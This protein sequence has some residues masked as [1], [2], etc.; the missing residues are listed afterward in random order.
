M[1]APSWDSLSSAPPSAPDW[2]SLSA[3][4]PPQ[5]GPAPAIVDPNAPPSW[6]DLQTAD[7]FHSGIG[8]TLM[9]AEEGA[10]RGA[11]GGFS[12]FVPQE[13][14]NNV[15]SA[16]TGGASDLF[17]N[18]T[19]TDT[20]EGIQS[21]LEA[22]PI[23]ETV[24]E[25]G[26][27][28]AMLAGTGGLGTEALAGKAGLEGLA[29]TVAANTAQGAIIGGAN[30]VSNDLAL[31]DPNLTAS[32]IA[33]DAGISALYGG[34]TGAVA[35][36]VLGGASKGLKSLANLKGSTIDGATQALSISPESLGPVDRLRIGLLSGLQDPEA[37]SQKVATGLDSLNDLTSLKNIA[38]VSGGSSDPAIQTFDEARSAF[39]K[40]FGK[41]KSYSI[42]PDEIMSF[43]TNPASKNSS[44][45]TIAFN[46]YFQAIKGLSGVELSDANL[47]NAVANAQGHLNDWLGMIPY[48]DQTT[49]YFDI[50][51]G[52]PGEGV[53]YST[54]YDLPKG[55]I[56]K[57]EGR[58]E[59]VTIG[60]G[61]NTGRVSTFGNER[62]SP[63]E[64]YN[65][66]SLR[67]MGTFS[68]QN[69][70]DTISSYQKELADLMDKQDEG[71]P[72]SADDIKYSLES[73]EEAGHQVKN[74]SK[75]QQ[76]IQNPPEPLGAG[77]ATIAAHV[78]YGSHLFALLSA[79][80]KYG[81]DGG[82]YR[83]GD[84]LASPLNILDGIANTAQRVDSKI[85]DKARL[86]FTGSSNQARKIGH[87]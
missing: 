84:T 69:I 60:S 83:L 65:T 22:H 16:M 11:T 28:A 25:I 18:M 30:S 33:S 1:A 42:D 54:K 73:G 76:A 24:G 59:G 35:S 36:S 78:P 27:T 37:L 72:F 34:V 39:L 66:N 31:G 14:K 70:S 63:F 71:L 23:A 43:I 55:E 40:E 74:L 10:E 62:V 48:A 57:E 7:Q 17:R 64:A 50:E 52:R 79:A 51:Y 32:K 6:D 86:I 81:G 44:Q 80:R 75:A 15:E 8:N 49:P 41:P 12:Q 13:L 5:P 21:N 58:M 2:K 68:R 47:N 87:E 29:A 19:G 20:A 67:R 3:S 46:H 9:A 61:A 53:P 38:A 4:P 85:S 56:P 82:L 45:Q 26:G 77:L